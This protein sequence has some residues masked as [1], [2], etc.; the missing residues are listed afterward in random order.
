MRALVVFESTWGGTRTVAEAVGRGI[1]ADTTVVE[2]ADVPGSLPADIDLLVVGGPTHAFSLS[3]RDTRRVRQGADEGHR[4]RGI[5]EWLDALPVSERLVVASFDTQVLKVTR[6]S[7]PPVRVA[8]THVRRRHLAGLVATESFYVDDADGRLA[9]G[10]LERA[11]SW[12]SE[13]TALRRGG[14]DTPE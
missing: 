11:E 2:V 8:G 12:G 1:E 13:L 3:R 7:A 6:R 10:E 4:R 5:R 9:T 14:L